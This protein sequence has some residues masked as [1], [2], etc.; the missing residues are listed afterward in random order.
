MPDLART[1][2]GWWYPEGKGPEHGALDININVALSY[3]GP[4]DPATG[5]S[6]N[7]GLPCRITRTNNMVVNR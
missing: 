3:D 1:G 2:M 6:D 5:S 4:W 7:R